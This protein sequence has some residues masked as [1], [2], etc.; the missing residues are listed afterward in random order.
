MT[1]IVAVVGNIV[2]VVAAVD[3][4][5]VV[6]ENSIE[7]VVDNSNLVEVEDPDSSTPYLLLFGSRMFE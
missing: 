5:L 2:V 4:D 3:M 6:D 7:V 1:S